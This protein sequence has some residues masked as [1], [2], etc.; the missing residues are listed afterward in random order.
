MRG[1]LGFAE[2]GRGI[3]GL[4]AAVD[5]A[6]EKK[7][8]DGLRRLIPEFSGGQAVPMHTPTTAAQPN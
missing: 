8:Y 7:V 6:D 1:A 3:D 2:L 5:G 4:L